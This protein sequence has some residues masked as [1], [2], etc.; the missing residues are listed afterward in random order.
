LQSFQKDLRKDIGSIKGQLQTKKFLFSKLEE[1]FKVF[2]D[3]QYR[4]ESELLE[5][6][7]GLALIAGQFNF[8]CSCSTFEAIQNSSDIHV[9]TDFS[10]VQL[11]FNY[12]S[13]LNSS[14]FN[15]YSSN[16]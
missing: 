6:S 9:I 8:V 2:P 13:F 15:Q 12:Y 1:V 10:L 5:I 14:I 11:L 4:R 3:F 7:N 16:T